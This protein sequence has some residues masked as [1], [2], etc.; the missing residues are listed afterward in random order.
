MADQPEQK[1]PADEMVLTDLKKS[2]SRIPLKPGESPQQN[3]WKKM[4]ALSSNQS[5]HQANSQQSSETTGSP[6]K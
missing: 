3:P 6:S 2:F 4:P 1:S 5:A